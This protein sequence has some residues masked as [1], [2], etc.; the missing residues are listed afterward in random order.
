MFANLNHRVSSRS[1]GEEVEVT[2][3][4]DTKLIAD[5]TY[6]EFTQWVHHM[7]PD[8]A[9]GSDGLNPAFF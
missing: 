1:G 5:L 8:K 4:R 9:S 6:E 3:E 2:E 7:H